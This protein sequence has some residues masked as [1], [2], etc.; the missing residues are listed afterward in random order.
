MP[1]NSTVIFG[2]GIIGVATAF[3]LSESSSHSGTIHLVEASPELFASASGKAGGLVA[4][5]WFGPAAAE[6]GV[7]SFRLHQELATE[8]DGGKRWGY[9]RTT[10]TSVVVGKSEQKKGET[11][12]E[13]G[14]SR[15]EVAA[16]EHVEHYAEGEGPAWMKKTRGGRVE[17]LS[18]DGGMAGAS[19]SQEVRGV[20]LHQPARATRVV[21]SDKIVIEDD[22]G[23]EESIPYTRLLITAGAWTAKV[24][25]TLF[26]DASIRIPVSHLAGYS[27]V[28]R[29]PRW[30]AKQ[31]ATGCHAVFASASE[32]WS[33]ELFNLYR[34]TQ[35][36]W[37]V[38]AAPAH[39]WDDFHVVREGLCFRPVTRSGNPVL[40]RIPDRKLNAELEANGKSSGS[41]FVCAGHGPWGI[42]L[43]LGTGKVMSEMLL[44]EELS[45][46]VSRL[47]M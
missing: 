23:K 4:E 25:S 15:A 31:E 13:Q 30:T 45:C 9:A 32:T 41:V 16:G 8:Y 42:S 14:G 47:G 36:S 46:D 27:L 18:E 20:K 24:F 40:A 29:S 12:L 26:Q 28:V 1:T 6:L 10:G 37:P 5:D 22:T 17:V 38:F 35:R 39:R 34:W 11:W 21:K 3:Y 44:G 33:P 43:S 7:L 2:A 19:R